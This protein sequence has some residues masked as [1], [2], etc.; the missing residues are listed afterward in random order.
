MMS[1]KTTKIKRP[2]K[3]GQII[4]ENILTCL[5]CGHDHENTDIIKHFNKRK[6]TILSCLCDKCHYPMRLRKTRL[7]FYVFSNQSSGQY[8]NKIDWNDVF[9]DC[10]LHISD[11]LKD[12]LIENY[13]PP[14]RAMSK[15]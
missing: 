8:Y 9:R 7:G 1:M 4:T 13:A 15:K 6:V 10:K 12:W 14:H 5:K 11:D 2:R 3:V